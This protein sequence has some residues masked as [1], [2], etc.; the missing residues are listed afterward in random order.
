M[1]PACLDPAILVATL[2]GQLLRLAARA[3]N[4]HI[5][6][7]QQG[8][9]VLCKLNLIDNRDSRTLRQLDVCYNI[10]RHVTAQ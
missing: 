7:L 9:A 4:Q 2:H 10:N 1:E 8:A 5:Q 6:G 3:A